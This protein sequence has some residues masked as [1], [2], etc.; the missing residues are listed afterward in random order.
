[1]ADFYRDRSDRHIRLMD[2]V[3]DAAFACDD[4]LDEFGV[5]DL[6][7]AHEAEYEVAKSALIAYRI[8]NHL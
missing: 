3:I 7:R 2:A 8:S 5:T 1:M 4:F 6:Y